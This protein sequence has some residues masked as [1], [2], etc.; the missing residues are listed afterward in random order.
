MVGGL[1]ARRQFERREKDA[2]DLPRDTLPCQLD[3][4]FGLAECPRVGMR[5]K[6]RVIAAIR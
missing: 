3:R 6:K 2:R 4:L 1:G 5:P